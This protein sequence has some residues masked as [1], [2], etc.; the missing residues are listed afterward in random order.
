MSKLPKTIRFPNPEEIKSIEDVKRQLKLILREI[1]RMHV[2]V[3]DHLDN[4]RVLVDEVDPGD[5][6][7][8][9]NVTYGRLGEIAF[10]GGDFFGK[11]TATGK[12]TNWVQINP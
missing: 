7:P 1:Q 9:A 3:K 11:T 2:M 6:D 12:D 5:G 8:T 10:Y 4:P